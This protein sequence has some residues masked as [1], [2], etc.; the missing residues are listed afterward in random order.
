MSD[1]ILIVVTSEMYKQGY[2]WSKDIDVLIDLRL[3]IPTVE[4]YILISH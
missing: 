4:L 3:D 1:V 2:C